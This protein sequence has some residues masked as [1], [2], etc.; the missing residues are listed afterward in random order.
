MKNIE[1]F[2][3]TTTDPDYDNYRFLQG[4]AADGSICT[5]IPLKYNFETRLIDASFTHEFIHDLVDLL[6]VSLTS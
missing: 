5:S 4:L 6:N 3:I 1:K 2:I